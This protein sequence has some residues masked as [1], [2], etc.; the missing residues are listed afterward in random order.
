MA[1]GRKLIFSLPERHL[2]R[3]TS[4]IVAFMYCNNY[5]SEDMDAEVHVVPQT[6][7]VVLCLL[8]VIADYLPRL[9][10]HEPFK[11]VVRDD[12][13]DDTFIK[14]FRFRK[15]DF[16]RLLAALGVTDAD[17]V[18]HTS[19]GRKLWAENYPLE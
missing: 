1:G 10:H 9:E 2:I 11:H 13:D 6:S 15:E 16:G 8:T 17:F 3:V 4:A 18:V 7:I 5:F 12:F 14:T 19:T